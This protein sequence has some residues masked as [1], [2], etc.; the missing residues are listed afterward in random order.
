MHA[1]IWTS[2]GQRFALPSAAVVEVVPV[3]HTTPLVH[4]PH[5]VKGVFNY[6]GTLIRL[7]DAATL[8]GHP[9]E[10]LRRAARILVIR[11]GAD[12]QQ[13]PTAPHMVGLLV[14]Q[15]LGSE[16]LAAASSPSPPP[17]GSP[18]FL[19]PVV[20]TEAGT[21]Q[22]IVPTALATVASHSTLPPPSPQSNSPAP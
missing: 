19:G 22:L 1:V 18:P 21:V 8:L 13:A 2:A 16:Q 5:E 3:V 12:P 10:E 7:L 9:A 6:R 4:G 17:S 20:L 11:T 15:L 14:P